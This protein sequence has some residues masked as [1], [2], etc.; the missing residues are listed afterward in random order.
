MSETDK[1]HKKE[2]DEKVEEVKK[3]LSLKVS[4]VNFLQ[5][6]CSSVPRVVIVSLCVIPM[7]W[8]LCCIY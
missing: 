4:Q 3:T 5:I 7:L 1:R 2:V 8:W 6:L